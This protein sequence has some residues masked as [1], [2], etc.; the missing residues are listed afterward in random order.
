MMLFR[1]RRSR[2]D[3]IVAAVRRTLRFR[4]VFM[5]VAWVISWFAALIAASSSISAQ[6]EKQT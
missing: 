5:A 1:R 6:R 3:R 2:K 4:R